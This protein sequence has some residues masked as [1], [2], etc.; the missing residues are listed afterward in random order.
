MP[1]SKDGKF[2]DNSDLLPGW[3]VNNNKSDNNK[4]DK[5]YLLLKR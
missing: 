4:K 2:N 3:Q 1:C 5:V